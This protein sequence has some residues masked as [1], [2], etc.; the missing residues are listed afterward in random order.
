MVLS[1]DPLRREAEG[2][3]LN[4][5][6]A[7]ATIQSSDSIVSTSLQQWPS[8]FGTVRLQQHSAVILADDSPLALGTRESEKVPR[9]SVRKIPSYSGGSLDSHFNDATLRS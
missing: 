9:K 3:N 1:Q 5:L 6:V 4:I 7:K 2:G 8:S